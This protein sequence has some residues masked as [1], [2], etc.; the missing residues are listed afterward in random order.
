MPPFRYVLLLGQGRSGT[1]WLLSAL[2]ESPVTFARNEPNAID[3]SSFAAISPI[4]SVDDIEP[5]HDAWDPLVQ[6][7]GVRVGHRDPRP[8]PFKN[9]LSPRSHRLHLDDLVYKHRVRGPIST[10]VP[11]LRGG[12]FPMPSWLVDEAAFGS[13]V[14][15]IKLNK[16][17]RV[18]A[19][20]LEHRPDVPVIH[21]IRHPGARHA[22][23]LERYATTVG[24]DV[25]L[26]DSRRELQWV[27]AR[28]PSWAERVGPVDELGLAE[29]ETWLWCYQSET[30]DSIGRR[31]GRRYLGLQYEH[32]LADPIEHA[33]RIYDLAGL[34]LDTATLERI[35]AGLSQSVWGQ[36][37]K[38]TAELR[39]GWRKKL[40]AEDQAAI[41]TI[42]DGSSLRSWW[43]DEIDD[44]PRSGNEP[45]ATDS[46]P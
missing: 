18:G 40:G 32:M 46:N 17:A 6:R 29:C 39:D 20:V 30:I 43:T 28:N 2:D 42:L 26:R 14:R 34:D 11:S 7:I 19:F 31:P 12:E 13:A 27:T 5:L 1:N 21:V 35:D 8:R 10:F 15:L 16:A 36:V 37:E 22:S 38:T 4:W 33:R 9:W 45:A 23:F 24:L 3:D 44:A 41:E 25:A